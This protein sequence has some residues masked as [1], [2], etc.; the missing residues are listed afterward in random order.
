MKLVFLTCFLVIYFV[1]VDALRRCTWSEMEL[2]EQELTEYARNP[3]NWSEERKS[4]LYCDIVQIRLD[5]LK[6]LECDH[7]KTIKGLAVSVDD[8]IG[9]I[10]PGLQRMKDY[11]L[12]ADS[13]TS[14]IE[15]D[16]DDD[17]DEYY[18]TKQCMDALSDYLKSRYSLTC[19][20]MLK[21]IPCF[22]LGRSRCGIPQVLDEGSGGVSPYVAIAE[23]GD[24][25]LYYNSSDPVYQRQED[26][27]TE[28]DLD[29]FAYF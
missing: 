24:C 4:V 16:Y 14:V 9:M 21:A 27:R 1:G 23:N 12:C 19:V 7:S 26:Y 25:V 11:G 3:D 17:C 8:W 18:V 6:S 10:S 15:I 5:Y 29:Y 13:S 2:F 20:V 28:H 22:T